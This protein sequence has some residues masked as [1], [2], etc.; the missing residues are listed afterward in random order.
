M[1]KRIVLFTLLVLPLGVFGQEKIAYFNPQEIYVIMPEFKQMQ[2][3]LQKTHAI[4]KKELDNLQDEYTKKYQALMEEGDKLIESIK[5]RRLQEIQGIEE[6]ANLYNEQAQQ[7][8][9]QLQQ[10]LLVPIQKK[11]NDAVQAV[12]AANNFLYILSG[13]VLLYT[14]PNAVDATPLIQKYLKL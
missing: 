13:E 3:S 2:D 7:E 8:L 11:V 1:L 10:A 9:M 12:G 14:S 6:R 5:L 4:M